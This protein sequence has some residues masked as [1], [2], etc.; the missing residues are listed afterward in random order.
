[1]KIDI[2][3]LGY[4]WKGLWS[5]GTT[6]TKGDVVRKDS[7]VQYY[8]GSIFQTMATSQLNATTKNELLTPGTTH[9]LTGVF[10][11]SLI[12]TASGELEFQFLEGR[13]GSAVAKLP[14][15]RFGDNGYTG[16]Q[17]HFGVIMT[18]GSVRM[19]G[20]QN[21]GQ[22]GD[23][24]YAERHR[25]MPVYAAF[26]PGTPPMAELYLSNYTTYAVDTDG[27]LWAWG[28]NNYGQVGVGNTTNNA[29]NNATP[30]LISGK[31]NLPADAKVTSVK[32]GTGYY[33][34]SSVMCQTEDGKV[35]YWGSNRY[36]SSGIPSTGTSNITTPRLVPTSTKH[37]IV[38]YGT[39]GHYHQF[40]WLVDSEGHLYMAGEQNSISRIQNNGDPNVE[41]QL[42]APSDKDPVL[43]VCSEE[44]DS[45]VSGGAQYQR[46]YMIITTNGKIYGWGESNSN[47]TITGV[48]V[49][50]SETW[51]ATEDTRLGSKFVV[52][53][54]CKA[55]I[56]TQQVVLLNDGT[57]WG[58]GVGQYNSL[59]NGTGDSNNWVQLSGIGS[60]N[61]EIVGGG[62]QYSAWGM[63]KGADGSLRGYGLNNYGHTGSGS[64]LDGY[65]GKTLFNQTIVDWRVGG[66]AVAASAHLVTYVLSD[67]GSLYSAGTGQYSMTGHTD[68]SEEL[69]VLSPVLF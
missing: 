2:S 51:V 4:R 49:P 8:T 28:N 24:V 37:T 3:K 63:T 46:R 59:L 29:N 68:D 18:D 44:S 50:G 38:N 39:V 69:P 55:G 22:L 60:D 16:G 26:P 45:H 30:K 54:Y 5:T 58:I 13:S 57:V 19:W 1:M 15:N 21:N 31:G 14:H 35:Y 47:T 34:Y 65:R 32:P 67:D 61:T 48:R 11:Q 42:W 62:C 27:K 7:K 64:I 40:S 23:G 10:G 56:Y 66:Y 12:V 25:S 20:R 53:G 52:D 36:C 43:K 33:N 41:H 17:D 6:Y 9:T